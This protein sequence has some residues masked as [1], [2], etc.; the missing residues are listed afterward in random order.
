MTDPARDPAPGGEPGPFEKFVALGN[1]FV[2]IHAPPDPERVRDVPKLTDRRTG[3][4][5]DGVIFIEPESPWRYQ[6]TLI[7][8]D[9][10]PAEFSGNGFASA[11]RAILDRYDALQPIELVS[12]GLVFPERLQGDEVVLLK[13]SRG[14]WDPN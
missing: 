1:D 12:R 7:N 3:V 11:A 10:T 8:A 6:L 2:L 9:G 14:S 13:A 5:A 4:G